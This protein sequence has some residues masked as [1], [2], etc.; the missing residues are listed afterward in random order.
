MSMS[1]KCIVD[2]VSVGKPPPPNY[3]TDI[4]TVMF[5]IFDFKSRE[6][7]RAELIESPMLKAHGYEWSIKIY[8]RGDSRSS[9]EREF[10]S[11]YLSLRQQVDLSAG[12]TFR[13]KKFEVS[14]LSSSLRFGG[15]QKDWGTHDF[16]DREIVC[17]SKLEGDGSLVIE[18]DIQIDAVHK[19]IWYPKK[20]Q[21]DIWIELYT[22]SE[23]SDVAFSV[24]ER[25]YRAHKNIL[26]FRAKKLF[27][28]A[29]E[30]DNVGPIPIHSMRGEI[31]KSIL[32]FVY[33]S[34]TPKI[35][36][37][38]FAIELLVAA[39]VYGC[40]HLKLYVESALV[41]KFLK[42]EN[43]AELFIFADSHSCALLKEAAIKLFV[44]DAETVKRTEAWSNIRESPQFLEEFLEELLAAGSNTFGK[45]DVT[46]LRKEL[47][48]AN[49]ALDG[50][51]EIL[52][53]RLKAHRARIDRR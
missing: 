7:G 6:E 27:E 12:F 52:I 34:K 48:E 3:P 44:A 20:L 41:D 36:N 18:I 30:C 16:L 31:F 43:A 15:S 26:A 14:Y 53:D 1:P 29:N 32:D 39:D 33:V 46:S 4:Q 49:L 24:E 8:P 9:I 28:I 42:A 17:Q 40:V 51:H 10:I 45:E 25:T 22:S 38:D 21:N 37:Q 19:H 23:T 11:C 2:Y 13:C 5:V 47:E 50:S 35:K